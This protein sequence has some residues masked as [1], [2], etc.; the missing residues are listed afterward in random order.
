MTSLPR[1][2]L[3]ELG[4]PSRRP[5]GQVHDT[6]RTAD[7]QDMSLIFVVALHVPYSECFVMASA[8]KMSSVGMPSNGIA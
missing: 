7:L 4:G 5:P 8:G 6:V 1:A 3:G 2:T